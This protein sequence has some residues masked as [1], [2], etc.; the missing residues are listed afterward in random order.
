MADQEQSKNPKANGGKKRPNEMISIPEEPKGALDFTDSNSTLQL[1]VADIEFVFTDGTLYANAAMILSLSDILFRG[2]IVDTWK[3]MERNDLHRV[4]YNMS[5]P[6]FC[7]LTKYRSILPVLYL[8]YGR[9]VVATRCIK[10]LFVDAA[11]FD[12]FLTF[13]DKIGCQALIGLIHKAIAERKDNHIA[14][15]PV[16]KKHSKH[17]KLPGLVEP[18]II[19]TSICLEASFF[20]NFFRKENLNPPKDATRKFYLDMFEDITD[21]EDIQFYWDNFSSPQDASTRSYA[22]HFL[23]LFNKKALIDTIDK[24]DLKRWTNA[25]ICSSAQWAQ[26]YTIPLLMEK[27]LRH[28]NS[29]EWKAK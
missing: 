28:V 16:L 14:I 29:V 5:D 15:Y 24:F 7:K 21:A 4:V 25:Q 6:A 10:D 2:M 9:P 12:E 26:T 19:G 22:L 27:L 8:A 20:S 18:Q 1:Q 13:A 17:G 3:T 11:V 23:L